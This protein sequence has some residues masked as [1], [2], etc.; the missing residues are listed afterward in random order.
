MHDF[1]PEHH[2][3]DPTSH[4]KTPP[5][6]QATNTSPTEPQRDPLTEHQLPAEQQRHE[7][8]DHA[9]PPCSQNA[10]DSIPPQP[11]QGTPGPK[12][13]H[14]APADRHAPDAPPSH[15][16]PAAAG[17]RP[18]PF[19]SSTGHQLRPPSTR[20]S[21]RHTAANRQLAAA[22]PRESDRSTSP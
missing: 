17:P 7:P 4:A 14:Q 3:H 13:S 1:P 8:A 9:N 16:N 11:R 22:R 21:T 19:R 15:P 5:S 2:G 18:D 12:T 20:T 10:H 6:R